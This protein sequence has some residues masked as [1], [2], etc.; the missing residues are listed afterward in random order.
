MSKWNININALDVA[1]WLC[2]PPDDLSIFTTILFGWGV[3]KMCRFTE[4]VVDFHDYN[5]SWLG[6][7]HSSLL[8]S[9]SGYCKF[10][11]VPLYTHN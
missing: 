6:K 9:N 5:K 8:H 4:Y 3:A 10:E 1:K 7:S 2:K 11:E